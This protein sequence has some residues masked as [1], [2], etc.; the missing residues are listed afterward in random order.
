MMGTK[1]IQGKSKRVAKRVLVISGGW[2]GHHPQEWAELVAAWLESKG[3][4]VHVSGSLDVLKNERLMVKMNLIVPIWSMG[5]LA[6]AQWD[7]LRNAVSGGVGMAGWHGGMCDSFREHTG[8][9]FLTG[10]QWV[11]HPGGII[12][13]K[14]KI[15]GVD[16]PLTRGLADFRMKSEQ[17]YMHTDPGNRVLATTVFS[18][19]HEGMG[20]IRG[21]VMPVVWKRRYGRGRVFYSSLGHSPEELETPEVFEIIKRGMSWAMR[22]RIV[23]EYSSNP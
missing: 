5:K 17:Y 11:A 18:G 10:G 14:V 8:Y 9:Q 19:R 7:G 3:H 15:A 20:W 12:S 1:R 22:G 23:P 13:Y 21:T 6:D 16:D 2:D 4:G